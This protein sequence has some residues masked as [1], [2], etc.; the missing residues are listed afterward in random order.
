[1]RPRYPGEMSW[2]V[3][4]RSWVVPGVPQL[5]IAIMSTATKN[6][7]L[8]LLFA[9]KY[10]AALYLT[11]STLQGRCS[12]RGSTLCGRLPLSSG[13]TGPASVDPCW[14][15]LVSQFGDML[16]HLRSQTWMLPSSE[17]EA[18]RGGS[19]VFQCRSDTWKCCMVTRWTAGGIGWKLLWWHFW[20]SPG[21][22][23][24]WSA[25]PQQSLPLSIGISPPTIRVYSKI[26]N[27]KSFTLSLQQRAM[28][29]PNCWLGFHWPAPT[30]HLIFICSNC[31]FL[32]ILNNSKIRS[33]CYSS[34]S[35]SPA[36]WAAPCRGD[37]DSV[38]LAYCAM[39]LHFD[40]SIL[41]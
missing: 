33:T 10:N 21:G 7:Q 36:R 15:L 26:T 4:E 35:F 1:M 25:P 37:Q 2:E 20:V 41:L 14:Y 8:C 16:D 29:F 19:L 28:W 31:K 40:N 24:L 34:H 18:S 6:A 3:G 12:P 27:W 13:R 22:C 30:S 32:S 17:E 39:L 5:H 23:V 11:S 9:A 38:A